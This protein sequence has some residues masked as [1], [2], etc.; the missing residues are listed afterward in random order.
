MY[1]EYVRQSWVKQLFAN[2]I[3]AVAVTGG[4]L[5]IANLASET[6]TIAQAKYGPLVLALIAICAFVANLG[7]AYILFRRSIR[8]ADP[9]HWRQ[10]RLEVNKRD[11][12]QAVQVFLG[13]FRRAVVSHVNQEPDFTVLFPDPGEGSADEAIRALL[14]DASRA[15]FERRTGGI[16]NGAAITARSRYLRDGRNARS[17][18]SVGCA[19]DSTRMAAAAGTEPQPVFIP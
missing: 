2:S 14:D 15:M 16:Q 6:S 5:A 10:L 18:F 19:R 13:R 4:T 17:W 9:A 12:R 1:A 11:V 7:T 3:A 8:F